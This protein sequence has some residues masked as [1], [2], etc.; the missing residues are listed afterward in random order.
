MKYLLAFTCLLSLLHAEEFVQSGSKVF[1]KRIFSGPRG[2]HGNRGQRGHHGK[3][4]PRG[5]RGPRGKTN[6]CPTYCQYVYGILPFKTQTVASM[7]EL[8]LR[9]I[10]IAGTPPYTVSPEISTTDGSTIISIAPDG[11]GWYEG[12]LSLALSLSELADTNHIINVQTFMKIS[13]DNGASFSNVLVSETL[14]SFSGTSCSTIITVPFNFEAVSSSGSFQF[15]IHNGFGENNSPL[16]YTATLH[17]YL[18]IHKI[19]EYSL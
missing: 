12:Q 15:A 17:S 9:T 19:G 1:E 2:H 5:R 6:T 13:R 4:G 14:F 16:S 11:F 3:R 8:Q 7:E 18:A 10:K